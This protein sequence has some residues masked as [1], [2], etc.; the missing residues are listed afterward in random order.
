M[1]VTGLRW[2]VWQ[3]SAVRESHCY[4]GWKKGSEDGGVLRNGVVEGIGDRRNDGWTE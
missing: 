1:R 4:S 3:L 2:S